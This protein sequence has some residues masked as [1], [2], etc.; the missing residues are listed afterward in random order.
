[1][2]A[3]PRGLTAEVL[4]VG[5]EL[6]LGQIA[7]TNA[8]HISSALADIGVDVYFHSAVGDNLERVVEALRIASGRSD[9]V[10]ITGGLGPTPDDLTSAAVATWLGRPL[11]RDERLAAVITE[12]FASLGRAM[13][14][15]N[16]KQADLP[17]GAMPID[18]VG[19]APGFIVERG[20]G[21][22]VALPGVPWEMKAMLESAGLPWL[23]G[24]AGDAVILSRLVWVLGLG[25][26][27]T[28]AL[29]AD[30]V[31]AQSNP[32]I[33]YLAGAGRV[34]VRITAKAATRAE[35][36]SL[37]APVERAVRE[38]L[39][40]ATLPEGSESLSQALGDLLVARGATVAAVES[41]T[42]GL[43]GAEF[44][45]V[46]GS[47]AYFLGSLV[48]YSTDAK[49]RLAGVE[50]AVVEGPGVVSEP[51][52]RALARAAADRFG[53]DLGIAAT[54]VAGPEPQEGK[55]PGTIFVGAS[56]GGRTE[57]RHVSARGDRANVTAF[58][59]TA[60]LDLGRRVLDSGP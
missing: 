25:E 14:E 13:P 6:L 55:P 4:G 17:E 1:L 22:L 39:G 38:R 60:A 5:T 37:I 30:I 35:A 49:R 12:I 58:A 33:A 18:P 20:R 36:G 46:P 43:I 10:V 27:A 34:R 15:E 31:E 50:E 23:R 16:L 52:A 41:L 26:S 42:G 51:A 40:E 44:T 7:N 21:G 3:E 54:G 32:T 47:S 57:V 2:S 11:V 19:T 28:H 45:S 48:C 8:Q 59:V 29:I 56:Y 53:A 9:V 24:K